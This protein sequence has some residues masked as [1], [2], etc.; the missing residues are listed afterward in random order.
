MAVNCESQQGE[1]LIAPMSQ[2]EGFMEMS[3]CFM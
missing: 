2:F 3:L 1:V